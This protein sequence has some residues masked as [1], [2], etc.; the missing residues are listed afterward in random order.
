MNEPTI[1]EQ[2]NTWIAECVLLIQAG[3][4]ADPTMHEKMIDAGRGGQLDHFLRHLLNS[5]NAQREQRIVHLTQLLTFASLV[6]KAGALGKTVV[7]AV[8]Q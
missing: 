6:A 5:H 1:E 2:L 8:K 7:I 3:Y 4:A